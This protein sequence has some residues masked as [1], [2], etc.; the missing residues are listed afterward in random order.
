MDADGSGSISLEEMM[1]GFDSSEPFQRLMQRLGRGSRGY[2]TELLRPL[3]AYKLPL[4]HPK[5][6]ES[7][8]KPSLYHPKMAEHKVQRAFLS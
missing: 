4:S 8:Y 7:P 1:E 5:L 6:A 2:G 3:Y